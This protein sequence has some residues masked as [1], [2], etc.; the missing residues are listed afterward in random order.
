MTEQVVAGV[1]SGPSPN[2]QWHWRP[3]DGTSTSVPVPP[4]LVD[5]L[6][7][8]ADNVRLRVR[9][10]ISGIQILGPEETGLNQE[11]PGILLNGEPLELPETPDVEPGVVVVAKVPYGRADPTVPEATA[12]YR[13][14]VVTK[15]YPGHVVVR[16]I[17]SK[18]A[19]G[20]GQRLREPVHAGLKPGAVVAND[21]EIISL[22]KIGVPKGRLTEVDRR[23]VGLPVGRQ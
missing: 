22:D 18:N 8:S 3:L 1:L 10:A 15:V 19:E 2:G 4:A 21:E 17:Y 23:L 7:T 14:V 5:P 9:K 16:P 11:P 20:H 13:P 6:W 12:K